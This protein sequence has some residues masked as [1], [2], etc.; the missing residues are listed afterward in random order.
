MYSS[1]CCIVVYN[2]SEN[3]IWMSSTLY[4]SI[5]L[6]PI[7]NSVIIITK[8]IKNFDNTSSLFST[9]ISRSFKVNFVCWSDI[10]GWCGRQASFSSA[11]ST[12]GQRGWYDNYPVATLSKLS[13]MC[14]FSLKD[15]QHFFL[16][17]VITC[18]ILCHALMQL[19]GLNLSFNHPLLHILVHG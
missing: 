2:T 8:I 17:C 3:V 19:Q 18:G 5:I 1:I 12:T 10:W 11:G 9:I 15:L 6:I 4:L 7:L 13:Q 16:T 14:L